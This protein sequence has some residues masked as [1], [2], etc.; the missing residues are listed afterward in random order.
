V[1]LVEERRRHAEELV[2]ESVARFSV[3]R[4]WWCE[5]LVAV[6]ERDRARTQR[7]RTQACRDRVRELQQR[8][9]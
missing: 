6:L 9:P 7:V 2:A 1:H 8:G 5:V 3:R 4:G